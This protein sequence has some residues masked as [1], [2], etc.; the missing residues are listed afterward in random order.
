[1]VSVLLQPFAVRPGWEHV[2]VCVPKSARAPGKPEAE[3][4]GAH[5]EAGRK[6]GAVGAVRGCPHSTGPRTAAAA[7]TPRGRVV[8]TITGMGAE[9][10]SFRSTRFISPWSD[11]FLNQNNPVSPYLV[12]T[13]FLLP[14]TPVSPL[15]DKMYYVQGTLCFCLNGCFSKGTGC[16]GGLQGLELV[17]AAPAEGWGVPALEV[18]KGCC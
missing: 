8:P 1:M 3:P 17:V 10:H 11:L 16:P 6:A 2:H 15:C 14:D 4:G 9:R 12:T 18:K 5:G 7:G 13:A